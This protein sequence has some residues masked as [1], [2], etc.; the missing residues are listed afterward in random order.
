MFAGYIDQGILER[1][2]ATAE[3]KAGFDFAGSHVPSVDNEKLV[4]WQAL[5]NAA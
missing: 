1:N 4:A 2:R 3:K 5:H